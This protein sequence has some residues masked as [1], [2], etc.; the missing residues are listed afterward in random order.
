MV[1]RL[2]EVPNTEKELASAERFLTTKRHVRISTSGA[3]EGKF[4]ADRNGRADATFPMW[5]I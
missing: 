1:E 2:G 3:G 5:H 4:L